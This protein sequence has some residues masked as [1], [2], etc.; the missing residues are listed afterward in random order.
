MKPCIIE[1]LSPLLC[2]PNVY[3]LDDIMLACRQVSNV[4]VSGVAW[5]PRVELCYIAHQNNTYKF[6][7]DL[8]T[9]FKVSSHHIEPLWI[10]YIQSTSSTVCNR[11]CAVEMS[12][13]LYTSAE[14][15]SITV[16]CLYKGQTPYA[17]HVA[18]FTH[19]LLGLSI[20]LWGIPPNSLH[21]T[22]DY[23]L[24]YKR[25]CFSEGIQFSWGTSFMKTMFCN[26]MEPNKAK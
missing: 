15:I 22:W 21:L 17:H 13:H 10:S 12:W 5:K 6:W 3:I 24:T 26:L 23:I 16:R 2:Y 19:Q 20:C 4:M 18:P 1:L 14:Y 11:I 7:S 9:C 8:C 25:L